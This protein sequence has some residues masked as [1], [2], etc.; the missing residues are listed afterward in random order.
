MVQAMSR[1]RLLACAIVV[2]AGAPTAC[3]RGSDHGASVVGPSSATA[4]AAATAART[5]TL[6][7]ARKGFQTRI[8]TQEGYES[9][10]PV[11]DPPKGL[12]ERITYHSP[13]GELA[14][15]ITPRPADSGRH[16]AVVWAHGGFG[17]IGAWLWK[18]PEPDDDQTASGLRE[19]GLVVM[20]P[21]WRGENENPG[22]FEMFYG[23]VDDLL[24]AADFV[25][26]L[27]WVDPTRVYL[28]GH[29]S[30]GTLV[31]LAA[32][33]SDRFRAAFAFGPWIG[34]DSDPKALKE[35]RLMN[36]IAVPFDVDRPQE[37]RLRSS[38]LFADAIR[39]PTFAF[40]GERN[41]LRGMQSFTRAASAANA[42]FSAY[43]AAGGDH[44]NIL[45]SLTRLVASRILSDT[46]SEC[47]IRI[48]EQDVSDAFAH[49]RTTKQ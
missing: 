49:R 45:Y 48:T 31:L 35:L 44:W 12:L 14:A 27:P 22:K 16:P 46:G 38:I 42:P 8:V 23:E 6:L 4:A 24:A 43:T 7:D 33:G 11:K 9:D 18:T 20:Y 37:A 29:S 47:G 5:P 19:A 15:Y 13:A 28:A 41:A 25:T 36:Q 39:R 40:E 3:S 30:G 1:S 26:G 32:T 10:G 2:F 34:L 21:S 17:G